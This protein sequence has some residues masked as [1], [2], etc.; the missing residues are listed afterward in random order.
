MANKEYSLLIIGNFENV[1]I[2]QF[3]KHL[4]RVNP[5]AHLFFWGYK[6][7]ENDSDR[8]FLQCY[9]EYYLFDVKY[10]MDTSLLWRFKAIDEMRKHF[11]TFVGSRH[12]DYINIHYVK[13]EYFF[14]LDCFKKHASS[15]VL[16]PW[17]SDVYGA[18]GLYKFLVK[19]LFNAANY[20]TG[21]NSRFTKDFK[22]IFN[23]P[24]RKLVHSE[25]GE[26]SVEYIID[27]KA[28]IGT[29]EA[30]RQLGID[31]HYAITCGYSAT[32]T[33]QH[34]AIIEAIDKVK[35]LLPE[36]LVLLFPLTYHK[37]PEHI[38]AIKKKVDECGLKAVYFE[39]FLD[40][41]NLFLLRQAT[42]MFIHVQTSDAASASLNEYLLCE[43]K[44]ING[45]WL[46]YPELIKNGVTPYFEVDCLENLG[47]RIVDVYKAEP[48][49][50]EKELV[51]D[52]E[53]KQW[54][55]TIK[56]WDALFSGNPKPINF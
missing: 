41:P 19:R 3:V 1:F 53:K 27:H 50:L 8:S 34:L 38:E 10:L 18:H 37:E 49:K 42:D 26:E 28:L 15:L 39:K 48:I 23:V 56:D 12:F 2:V 11:K 25:I 46:K 55:V 6:R 44:V 22:S 45:A 17:G 43:K 31:G 4:K 16:T 13:S 5:Q 20:V 51:E 14:V 36:R 47:K 7:S 30:K 29:N 21:G 9:D 35:T 24:C 33:Q 40:I 32:K 52:F 54:K